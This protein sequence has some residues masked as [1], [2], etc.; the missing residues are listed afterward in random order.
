MEWKDL[1]GKIVNQLPL[2]GTLFAGATGTTVGSAIK[3]VANTLGVEGTPDAIDNALAG[4]PDAMIKLKELELTHKVE[5]EKIILEQEIARTVD[6]ANARA[7]NIASL[8]Q[9]DSFIKRF[10]YYYASIVTFITFAYIF[11]ITFI[12][13][14]ELNIRFADTV[15]GFLLGTL[16]STMVNFFFGTSSGSL[17]KTQMIDKL[18]KGSK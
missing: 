5:L 3:L 7:M 17:A 2:I 13:I 15:L 12:S 11:L 16:I 6:V 9:G 10:I 4:N 1:A 14:P 18:I 8:Q